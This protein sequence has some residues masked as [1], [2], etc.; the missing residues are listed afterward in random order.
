MVLPRP[1]GTSP[2]DCKIQ[3]KMENVEGRPTECITKCLIEYPS[4]MTR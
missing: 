1:R 2:F 4:G 3:I